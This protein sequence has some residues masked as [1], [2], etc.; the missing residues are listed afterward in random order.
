[1]TKS[2]LWFEELKELIESGAL[3]VTE[4]KGFAVQAD[5]VRIQCKQGFVAEHGPVEFLFDFLEQT[6]LFKELAVLPHP[7]QDAFLCFFV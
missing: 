7:L 4:E 2:E 5:P 1:M 3:E 6:G